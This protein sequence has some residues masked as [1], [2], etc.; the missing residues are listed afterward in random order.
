MARRPLPLLLVVLVGALA[1][2]GA[3]GDGSSKATSAPS[4]G[5]TAGP[6]PVAHTAALHLRR[7]GSFDQPLYVTSPPGDASRLFVVEQPG[8]IRVIRGGRKLSTPFLDISGKV[9]CCGER[10]LLSMAFAPNFVRTHR[11]YVDYTDTNGDSNI[12]EYRASTTHPDRAIASS[13]RRVIFQ[14]QPEANHNGGL[15]VFGPDRLLYVGL[16][17]GGGGGDVH[18]RNGNGQNLRTL[19]G[20]ILRIDPRRHGRRRYGVPGD[21]PFA[22]R[23]GVRPEIFAYGLRNPWRFSFDARTGDMAIGDV[24]ESRIEEVDF[25]RAGHAAGVNYGWRVFEGRSRFASGRAFRAVAPVLQYSHVHGCSVTGGYVVRDPRLP[26]LAGRYLY[27]D[28]C[29]G[30]LFT[31]LLRP[32]SARRNHALGLGIPE[33]TSFG[34][35]AARRLY[36]TSARGAVL[37]LDPR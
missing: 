7:V 32:G 33:L 23:R 27:G 25:A 36:V 37:R 1:A 2:C 28:Y 15:L 21:N 31:A 13:A 14:R 35:D 3:G 24:G 8:R 12:V 17:D 6:R 30:R 18:G 5:S 20:K 10:G 29:A 16:G 26:A 19:L 22:R 11:F 34:Q 9:G 4:P